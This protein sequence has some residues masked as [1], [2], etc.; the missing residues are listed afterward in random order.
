MSLN[1][2]IY[3]GELKEIGTDN[4]IKGLKVTGINIVYRD[5]YQNN[6]QYPYTFEIYIE[7]V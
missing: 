2:S 4:T 5:K 6:V 3:K 7:E 1:R